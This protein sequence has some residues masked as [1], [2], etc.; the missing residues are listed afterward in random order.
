MDKETAQKVK[1][2]SKPVFWGLLGIGGIAMLGGIIMFIYV[3]PRDMAT[4]DQV[5]RDA[6]LM[7]TNVFLEQLAHNN[8][9]GRYAAALIEIGIAPEQCAQYS[10]RL[11]VPPDGKSFLFRLSKDGRTWG[12]SEKSPMP[13]ALK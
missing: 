1:D 13:K 5:P 8:E 2:G 6:A 11:T 10:C 3:V 7:F 9:K 12:L 4:G